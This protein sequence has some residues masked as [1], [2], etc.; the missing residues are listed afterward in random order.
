METKALIDALV[1]YFE[2]TPV[3]FVCAYL[4][5]SYARAEARPD[6]DIDVAVLLP[7][8]AARGL[9]GPSV[10]IRGELERRLGRPVDVVDMRGAPPDLI[11]RILRD[12]RLISEPNAR[13]RVRF[14]VRARNEYFDLLPHIHRYR[15]GEAA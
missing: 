2:E 6:S 9:L 10:G 8:S 1:A 12:G 4:F 11:H 5:G 7:E 14:E 13:E 3:P 15:S